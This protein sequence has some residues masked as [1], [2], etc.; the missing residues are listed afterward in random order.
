MFV[1]KIEAMETIIPIIVILLALLAL[2]FE[3]R[4]LLQKS[5][6]ALLALSLVSVT[7]LGFAESDPQTR[8]IGALG[9]MIIIG[10]IAGLLLKKYGE[11]LAVAGTLLSLTLMS[12]KASYFGFDLTFQGILIWLPL[13]GAIGP[14]LIR[15]K[16]QLLNRWTGM[17]ASR[18]ILAANVF[19]AAILTF[20]ATFQA[21]Y[22]GV[23]MIASGW[24][25]VALASRSMNISNGGIALLTIGFAFLV[26]KTQASF[27]D[28]WMRGNVMMGL[29][30]GAA[31]VLWTVVASK[32]TRF[33]WILM[34]LIP[35]L[36]VTAMVM[37]GKANE[38]FGGIPAYI[39][40]LVGSSIGLLLS[41]NEQQTI[42][43]Q[44]LLIGMSGLVLSQFEPVK[45]P[46]K[47]TR[48]EQQPVTTE[49]EQEPDILAVPAI[50]LD[51]TMSG[52]W[53]SAEEAS[54]LDFK[55]GPEGG[56]TKGGVE[57]FDVVLKMN[58]AGEPEQITVVIPTVKV[59]TFNSMRDESVHGAGYLN[60]PAFPKMGYTST[61]IKKEGDKY[62]VDG[63]FEMLGKKSLVKLEL[64]FAAKGVDKGKNYLVMVGKSALDRTK[65]GMASDSKIGDIVDVTFE[66]E[67]RK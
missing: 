14:V 25:A 27:D 4:P 53:K 18:T 16:A 28:S 3:E 36:V 39:G 50:A 17:E 65:F 42:P 33:R 20:F 21:S 38:H 15:W 8:I 12:V 43:F 2:I 6:F 62:I 29:I 11:W 46:E 9:G 52:K 13:L 23:V 51:A 5:A 64:K 55:L 59:T 41:G 40:A 37:M 24:M 22:F 44:A 61:T 57:D 45:M 30:A 63:N 1:K 49:T 35:V 7:H 34:Y 19:Y 10:W 32:A 54:K 26:A 56:V 66:V 48:L 47:K 67:F 60:A 58:A 31:A